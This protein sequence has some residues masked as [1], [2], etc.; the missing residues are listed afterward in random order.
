MAPF[1]EICNFSAMYRSTNFL[2][3]FGYRGWMEEILTEIC[4]CFEKGIFTLYNIL[5]FEFKMSPN[6]LWGFK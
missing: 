4:V 6:F 5:T 2:S 3:L 1:R